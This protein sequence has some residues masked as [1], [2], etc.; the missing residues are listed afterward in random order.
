METTWAGTTLRIPR[1][2]HEKV[3]AGVRLGTI[4]AAGGTA[5]VLVSHPALASGTPVPARTTIPVSPADSGRQAVLVF[6]NGDPALPMVTGI[7]LDELESA[8]PAARGARREAVLELDAG[9]ELVLRCGKSSIV[10]RADGEIVIRGVRIV[11]R[12]S[13]TNKV[14]GATV[15]LN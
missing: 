3:I 14:K 6:E 13:R 7:L 4:V 10:L 15:Q 9:R 2:R 8:R 11:S 5:G 1:A 12:A